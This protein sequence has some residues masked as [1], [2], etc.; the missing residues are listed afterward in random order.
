MYKTAARGSGF[1]HAVRLNLT[2][3]SCG[4]GETEEFVSLRGMER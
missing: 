2:G 1:R 4:M 3:I